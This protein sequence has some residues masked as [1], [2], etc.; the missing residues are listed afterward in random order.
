MS[1]V[2]FVR[3]LPLDTSESELTRVLSTYGLIDKVYLMI[4]KA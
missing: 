1:R 2:L 3:G 4:S